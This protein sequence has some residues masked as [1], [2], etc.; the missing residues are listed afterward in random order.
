MTMNYVLQ[1]VKSIQDPCCITILLNTHRTLPDNEKD[2]ILLKNLIKEAANRLPAECTDADA[3]S[4]I[5]K[6]H[7]LADSIDHRHNL[8]SLALFVNKDVAEYARMPVRT[9]NR[10]VI[11]DT[12]ATRDLLRAMNEEKSYYVLVL[13]RDKARLIHAHNDRLVYEPMGAFPRINTFLD[14]MQDN[15]APLGDHGLVLQQEFL[16][17][18]DK[19]VQEVVNHIPRRVLVCAEEST[20]HHFMKEADKKTFYMGPV[21]GNRTDE[22]AAQIVRDVWPTVLQ[23]RKEEL[24]QRTEELEKAQGAGQVLSDINDIWRA[25]NEGRGRTV[26]VQKGFIQPVR[27]AGDALE[28]LQPGN[29]TTADRTN[30][31]DDIVD[32]IVEVNAQ[33]GGD[34]V[35]VGDGD[36][37]PYNGIALVTRY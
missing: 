5:E 16:N 14:P 21:F 35:F 12:F 31:I 13:G 4:L 3:H 32:D 15:S 22:K 28:L 26:F 6:L 23:I 19:K 37:A 18:V 10:V 8:E 20:Y 1:K 30:L 17:D 11:G 2:P 27:H 36:L 34:T 24:R 33:K 29:G 25:V 7:Q 9:E